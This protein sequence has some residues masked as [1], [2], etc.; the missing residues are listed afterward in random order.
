MHGMMTYQLG[1]SPH[2]VLCLVLSLWLRLGQCGKITLQLTGH[3]VVWP[4]AWHKSQP[5]I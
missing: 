3:E 5:Q 2:E 4:Y 1:V